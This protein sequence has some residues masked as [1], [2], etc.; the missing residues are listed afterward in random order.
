MVLPPP[1]STRLLTIVA[2]VD[3]G[4]TTLADSLVESNGIISERLA[5][6]IRYLDS[7]EEEQKRGITMRCSAIGLRHR[8]CPNPKAEAQNVVVHLIDSPG[9]V[10]FSAEVTTSLL[11]CDGALLVVDA[12]EGM[13]ARTHNILREAYAAQLVPVLVINKVDRL[14]T[15]LGLGC[16]EAYMRLR[17]LIESVNAASAAM[18][19][20][21][22]ALGG[23]DADDTNGNGCN[24]TKND[25]MAK[26]EEEEEGLWNF[27]PAK[28]NVVF[29]SALHGWGF[30]VP[31]L[32]RS[33]FRSKTVPIKPPVLRQYLFDDVKYRHRDGKVIKWKREQSGSDDENMTMFSEFAL[34][35]LWDAYEGVSTAAA[36]VDV[37]SGRDTKIK[38][39]T[40]G[41]DALLEAMQLG[42]TAS[43]FGDNG[44]DDLH[45]NPQTAEQMQHILQRTG[46]N[47]S[48]AVLR[49]LLRRYRPLS[50][51]VLDAACEHCPDPSIASSTI[52]TRALAVDDFPS[53]TSG[54]NGEASGD[55]A[56]ALGDLHRI[57]K[58]VKQCDT[59]P[60]APTVAHVC[61]FVVTDRASVTDS[62]LPSLQGEN[63]EPLSMIMGLTRVLSGTLKS[64]D[65]EYFCFGPKHIPGAKIAQKKLRLYLL[66]GSSFVKVDSVPAGHICAVY[67]LEDLQLKTVT[68]CDSSRGMPIRGFHHGLKPLVKVNVEPMLASDTT[69][70]EKGLVK[71]ALADASVEVTATSKGERLLSCLGEIHLEQSIHDL[72]KTYCGKEIKLRV[73][74]PI[75][76]FG[77]CTAWFENETSTDFEQ[78]FDDKSPPLRQIT[79]PPYCYEEGIG[80]AHRG[81][82]RALLS[83]RPAAI[84]LRV[85]PLTPNAYRSL[86]AGTV[87]GDSEDD[88]CA[89]GRALGCGEGCDAGRILET[90]LASSCTL[91]NTG[92][93]MIEAAGVRNGTCIKAVFT[94]NGEVYVP[95]STVGDNTSTQQNGEKKDGELEEEDAD[96]A[97][98]RK[99]YGD[100][101][102][103]IRVE[104]LAGN[105]GLELPSKDDLSVANPATAIWQD[106]MKVSVAAGFQLAMRSGPFC[107]ERVRGVLAVVEGIEIALTSSQPHKSVKPV[108]G[109]M[110]VA[111]LRS[112][113]RCALLSRPARLVEGHLRLTLHSS[114]TGLGPLHAVL[115]RRRGKVLT[116]DMV[117]GTDLIRVTANLPQAES[118]HLAP[119]LLKESS[120]EVT[121]PEL[122]FSH[123]EVLEEDPFWIPT[124]LEEREDFGEILM[125]GDSSTGIKNN[126]LKYIRAVR[127]RKGLLVDSKKI[128]VAAEKQRTLARKK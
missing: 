1:S 57:Q 86:K 34:R 127:D 69:A 74:E 116:D 80:H 46:A 93:A 115:S 28:G 111:A 68:L 55:E 87:V 18:I 70:L 14:C 39:D 9:H 97:I 98:G 47:S 27:E 106:E 45:S 36:C 17:E 92:N 110:V 75:V 66:M 85:L 96:V 6:S 16:N 108:G 49:A 3:H 118:F 25:D 11:A 22:R 50:D 10:D 51:A 43:A 60:D 117:E 88:I 58:A 23:D 112:G 99:V 35:P 13:C 59:S 83:G 30:T 29:C 90:I 119:E 64:E 81:R 54:S 44:G 67:D 40:P 102:S 113:I 125:S 56:D 84:S 78:L 38:A 20:S 100:L 124:S 32:A 33:L 41:M 24:E 91:D 21:A 120:G 48:E 122:V 76:D 71:L 5:G 82:C 126:A 15:D 63:G 26:K 4:K 79:I 123:W 128:V 12:V 121:A 107:E 105:N 73:S 52:R 19:R 104:G 95:P 42:S 109:G 114:F 101:R 103:T 65:A 62:G 8:Y 94:E 37:G 72:E 61:K 7:L 31:S 2:H 77:E 89:L 53:G